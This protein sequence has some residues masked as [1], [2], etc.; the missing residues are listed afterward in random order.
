MKVTAEGIE[1]AEQ[2]AALRRLDC[3]FGQGYFFSPAI[4][5]DAVQQLLASGKKW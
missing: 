4:A 3:D 1:N 5:P 2:L